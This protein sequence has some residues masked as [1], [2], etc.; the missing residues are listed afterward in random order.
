[1]TLKR[2]GLFCFPIKHSTHTTH[3]HTHTHTQRE[4]ERERERERQTPARPQSARGWSTRRC[5]AC[6]RVCVCVYVC[7]CVCMCVRFMCVR[8]CVCLSVCV[9]LC[10]RVRHG[11]SV[12]YSEFLIFFVNCLYSAPPSAPGLFRISNPSPEASC[13]PS[14]THV[15]ALC[16]RQHSG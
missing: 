9:C 4:R 12:V 15:S 1:M 6:L 10:M 11:I 2:V 5:V 14:S 3:T 8:V 16:T 7:V 13:G